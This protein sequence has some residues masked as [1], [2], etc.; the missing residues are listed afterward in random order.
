MSTYDT[1]GLLMRSDL[2]LLRGAGPGQHSLGRLIIFALG[3]FGTL[4][5]FTTSLS[6]LPDEVR[7]AYYLAGLGC[8]WAALLLRFLL[9]PVS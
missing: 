4:L 3:A 5:A 9:E 8:F 6:A 7:R 2:Q 1:P